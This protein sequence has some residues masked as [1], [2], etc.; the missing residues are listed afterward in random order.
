MLTKRIIPCLDVKDGRVVKGVSFV[1][2]K[3]AGDPVDAAKA[4]EEQG[5]DELVFL[6]I[7]ASHEKRK[8]ILDV[9]EETASEVFMPL[10]VGGGIRTLDDIK[11][12]LRSG[13]DKVSINT[14]A[15]EDPEFVRRASE[16]FGSQCI[17][18]AIDA[19]RKAGGGW[20]VYTHGGRKA[21]GLDVVEWAKKV[22]SLGA[23]EILLT[24][25]DRDGRKDGYDLDLTS[26]VSLNTSIPVI[27]SGG[28]GTLEH[29]YEAFTKGRADAALAASIFHFGVFTIP[30]TKEY[31]QSK[32]IRVR[33]PGMTGTR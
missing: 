15:V 31:L 8:T 5:A 12:L 22:E 6:D 1:E 28:A 33:P 17:V 27:A 25:M 10:T 19:K 21:R 2:L 9:V 29:I 18:V 16:R 4:Y 30:E 3:D 7:T 20:E 26:E 13:T 23:G 24:S 32:G 14:T 11:E